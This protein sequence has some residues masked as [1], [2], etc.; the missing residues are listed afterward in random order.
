MSR[1][2]NDDTLLVN[3]NDACI[4]Q[5]DLRLLES[6]SG[7]LN[8]SCIFYYTQRLMDSN[9][10]FDKASDVILD[11]SVLSFLVHQCG[12]LQDLEEFAE[13]RQYWKGTR[14]VFMPINDNMGQANWTTPGMGAHWSLLL[15][16]ISVNEA[17]G[18]DTSTMS[19]SSRSFQYLHFD[20]IAASPNIQAA[21]VVARQWYKT[22]STEALNANIKDIRQRVEIES[23]R[24]PMQSNGYDCGLH[25]L[26]AIR[27]L[28]FTQEVVS[29]ENS[30]TI[31]T[32]A[33]PCSSSST[34]GVRR[35][36][37]E[38]LR[39]T[40]GAK[41]KQDPQYMRKLRQEI[42]EDVLTQ[43]KAQL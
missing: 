6:P 17:A 2:I 8:D 33:P 43:A 19:E 18:Q 21:N 27:E 23:C 35:I 39:A 30:D 41:L 29:S 32:T 34:G 28:L 11:P 7:W 9:A 16:I 14:R 12:D 15:V 37:E 20:S 36:C 25:V 26:T 4:Y 5:R 13:S 10:H 1:F 38:H 42:I 22:T 40:L 24:T 31:T 3:Y